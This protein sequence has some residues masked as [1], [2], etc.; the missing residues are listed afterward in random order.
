M[1]ATDTDVPKL[2]SWLG[3]RPD[4]KAH[5]RIEIRKVKAESGFLPL[6]VPEID[7][8]Y[9]YAI[10][11]DY[12]KD[13]TQTPLLVQELKKGTIPTLAGTSSSFPYSGWIPKTESE[14]PG[15][16]KV[17]SSRRTRAP[18]WSS[19]FRNRTWL[20]RRAGR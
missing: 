10:Y 13:G 14:V 1:K 6:A 5:A 15:N 12:S 4:I 20:R 17:L 7:P 18:A 16:T 9:V 3:I 11:V 2:F 19:S 8:N